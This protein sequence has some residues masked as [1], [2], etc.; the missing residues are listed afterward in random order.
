MAEASSSSLS[1][2]KTAKHAA[3]NILKAHARL[4]TLIKTFEMVEDIFLA[5]A[6][7]IGSCMALACESGLIVGFSFITIW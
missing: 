1:L 4:W 5:G 6:L 3:E 7:A 2:L